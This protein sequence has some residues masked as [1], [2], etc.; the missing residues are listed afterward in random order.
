MADQYL[1]IVNDFGTTQVG[2]DFRNIALRHSGRV[3]DLSYSTFSAGLTG[4]GAGGS[5]TV[6]KYSTTLACQMPIVAVVPPL[7]TTYGISTGNMANNGDGTYTFNFYSS[8]NGNPSGAHVDSSCLFYIFDLPQPNSDNFGV[9]F[10]ADDGTTVVF[11][12]IYKYLRIYGKYPFTTQPS[13]ATYGG[14]YATWP[15]AYSSYYNPSGIVPAISHE[16]PGT[17]W[18]NGPGFDGGPVTLSNYC[19]SLPMYVRDSSGIRWYW[20]IVEDEFLTTAGQP[21]PVNQPRENVAN[22]TNY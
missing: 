20:A 19:L 17:A 11:D 18:A 13:A 8:A 15:P 1:A 21:A 16:H 22:V 3:T 12:A 5:A 10:L 4:A 6:E 7:N 14:S 2:E 9:E